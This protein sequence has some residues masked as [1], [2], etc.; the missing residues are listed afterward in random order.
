MVCSD[1]GKVR[2]GIETGGYVFVFFLPLRRTHIHIRRQ[3]WNSYPICSNINQVK[4]LP[5]EKLSCHLTFDQKM[6]T[7]SNIVIVSKGSSVS[8]LFVCLLGI[9][10][11]CSFLFLKIYNKKHTHNQLK[12]RSITTRRC[13]WVLR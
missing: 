9:M 10:G 11:M 8:L 12:S 5:Q 7:A 3:V 13:R 1:V 4:E 2:S 6:R